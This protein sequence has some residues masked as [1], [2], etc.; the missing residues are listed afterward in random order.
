MPVPIAADSAS[1]LTEI[2]PL[3]IMIEEQA[4][5]TGVPMPA[6]ARPDALTA[7][8]PT[9]V[10]ARLTFEYCIQ[11]ICRRLISRSSKIRI[12]VELEIVM[13]SFIATFVKRTRTSELEREMDADASPLPVIERGR[14]IV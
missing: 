1:P 5:F 3:Q 8:E 4:P 14:V 7:T 11:T 10:A 2:D 6:P 13:A 12:A 9:S